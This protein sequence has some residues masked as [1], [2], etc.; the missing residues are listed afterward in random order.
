MKMSKIAEAIESVG[1]DR[2]ERTIDLEDRDTENENEHEDVKENS[3]LD[4]ESV[5]HRDS[6]G[7]DA[8]AILKNEK[9]QDL[10]NRLTTR[11]D[12]EKSRRNRGERKR[13]REPSR[14]STVDLLHFAEIETRERNREDDGDRLT[15]ADKRFD[16]AGRLRLLH[17][18]GEHERHK[19]TLNEHVD[20][21][22]SEML[23]RNHERQKSDHKA[24]KAD[25]ANRIREARNTGESEI[26][27]DERRKKDITEKVHF[28]RASITSAST[29]QPKALANTNGVRVKR[30]RAIELSTAPITTPMARVNT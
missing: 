19:N 13:N 30:I 21:G 24:L 1:V 14:V 28:V 2:R 20:S 26:D 12:D 27:N 22:K 8:H 15:E 4:D 3:E 6:R 7:K 16:L 10:R 18:V 25:D 29:A 9:A 5:L 23:T 11:D 17:R